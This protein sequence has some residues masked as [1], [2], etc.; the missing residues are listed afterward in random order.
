M[1]PLQT[2]L[3]T[4]GLEALAAYG[5][6]LAGG[7]ALQVHGYGTRESDDIDLFTNVLDPENFTEA[8]EQ[9]VTAYRA[10]GLTI[11]V[12]RQVS[13][14]AR[15]VV[16]DDD[17]TTAKADLAV[18]HRLLPPTTTSLGPVLS[19]AD[20]IGSKV[21]AVYS[22][23]EPRDL[24]DVQA[25]LDSDRYTTDALLALADQREVTPL[26]RK[27]FAGQLRAGSRLPDAGFQWYGATP[28]LIARIR[29]TAEEWAERL[30]RSS[31]R[32][33]G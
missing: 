30:D 18:D 12:A 29:R 31:G 32:M 20:A 25:V 10:S 33:D 4:I 7:Y 5:F 26:D 17:G 8:V 13:T 1:N 15:L 28:E 22:R 6:V 11:E 21:G 23:L 2:K 16:M 19:E 24:I 9:L 14:F 27:M 3:A